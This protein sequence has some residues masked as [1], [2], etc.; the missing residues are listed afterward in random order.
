MAKPAQK[1]QQKFQ[2]SRKKLAEQRDEAPEPVDPVWLVK[3]IA[4]TLILAAICSYITFCFL[5]YQ[6]QWQLVLHPAHTSK[7]PETVGG[8]Q[9]EL[10]HFAPDASA[11]PQ[12][13]G[14][15]IPAP[16]NGRYAATTLLFLPGEKGSMADSIPML[17]TL[18]ALGINI[19]AFDYR[20]YGQSA[21]VHP[22]QMRM[23][24]DAEAAWHYLT[25][26]RHILPTQIVPY[27]FGV[28]ATLA[29]HLA[30]EHGAIPGVVLDSPQ[31]DLINVARRDPR[32]KLL[33]L[34][35]LFHEDFPLASPLTT[36]RTPKLIVYGDPGVPP[37]VFR[38]A[39]DPKYIVGLPVQ[40]VNIYKQSVTRFLDEYLPH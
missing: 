23:T 11:T 36:L 14:W 15:W 29:M 12:L 18:H 33:P 27:G 39:L 28:G 38:K 40:D 2:Q 34:G 37:E 7:A 32:T 8:A 24:D 1:S 9:Y 19:F 31:G 10:I 6:G 16:A 3:A 17:A 25:G 35:L 20:G 30:S 4:A 13:V 26:S 22:N 21:A 5:F